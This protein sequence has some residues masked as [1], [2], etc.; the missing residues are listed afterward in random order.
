MNGPQQTACLAK[1]CINNQYQLFKSMTKWDSGQPTDGRNDRQTICKSYV[2][3]VPLPDK[4][5]TLDLGAL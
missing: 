1:G 5:Q 3:P 4:K 2:W